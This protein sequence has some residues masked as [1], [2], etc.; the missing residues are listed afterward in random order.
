[1]LGKERGLLLRCLYL[2]LELDITVP[3]VEDA[4]EKFRTRAPP[5]VPRRVV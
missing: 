1:M 5:K 3:A 2:P 4:L